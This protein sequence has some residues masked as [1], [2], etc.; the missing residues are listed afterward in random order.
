[1]SIETVVCSTEGVDE[2]VRRAC[3]DKQFRELLVNNPESALE[4]IGVAL[5]KGQRVIV[6]DF[7]IEEPPPLI[8]NLPPLGAELFVANAYTE[9][10][11][12]DAVSNRD[13]RN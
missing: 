2:A 5:Q 8:I 1:M 10:E 7:S 6:V 4:Q 9:G 3:V 13:G 11:I 12:V